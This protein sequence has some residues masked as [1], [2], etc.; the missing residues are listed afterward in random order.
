MNYLILF[1]EGFIAKII[2]GMDDT[3]THTPIISSLTSSKKGKL[4]FISG[5]FFSILTLIIISIFFA[6]FLQRIPYKHIIAAGLLL[7][8]AIFIFF[9]KVVHKGRKRYQKKIKKEITN[10]KFLRLLFLGFITFFATGIDDVIV[11]SSLLLKEFSLQIFVVGGILIAAFLEFFIIFNF[12][13][14]IAKIRYKERITVIGLII[15]AILVGF[16][17]I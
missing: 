9:D 11:Y 8:I 3:L 16:Q 13:R 14:A 12:S 15:L 7:I 1:I 2:T 10:V 5:M 4:V 17:I 6:N